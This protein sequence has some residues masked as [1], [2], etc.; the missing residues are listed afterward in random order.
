MNLLIVIVFS[1]L[2]L[3]NRSFAASDCEIFAKQ[4]E[5]KLSLI[6][7]ASFAKSIVD[8]IRENPYVFDHFK[9]TGKLSESLELNDHLIGVHWIDGTSEPRVYQLTLAGKTS[10]NIEIPRGWWAKI[11]AEKEF[12]GEAL[13]IST[14]QSL[15]APVV[16]EITVPNK[17]EKQQPSP[18][19]SVNANFPEDRLSYVGNKALW[20]N[21]G[22]KTLMLIVVEVARVLGV[23]TST[24]T[25]I[26]AFNFG[27]VSSKQDFGA[28]MRHFANSRGYHELNEV[29]LKF[30]YEFAPDNILVFNAP[31]SPF[32]TISRFLETS[33]RPN[34][35]EVYR[36]FRSVGELEA[37]AVGFEKSLRY[38]HD[39]LNDIITKIEK[40]Q[41]LSASQKLELQTLKQNNSP[42]A[43]D[44]KLNYIFSRFKLKNNDE[45]DLTHKAA[46]IQRLMENS[47]P[48]KIQFRRIA[49]YS[50]AL[51]PM[52]EY[53][54]RLFVKVMHDHL[55]KL[56]LANPEI[57]APRIRASVPV[58]FKLIPN[59]E[60][61]TKEITK[62]IVEAVT[63]E[64][65]VATAKKNS[66]NAKHSAER[67][68]EL[69]KVMS[70]VAN[71]T[72]NE[73]LNLALEGRAVTG[74]HF[75]KVMETAIALRGYNLE[76]GSMI[77]GLRLSV[78]GMGFR[79]E[80]TDFKHLIESTSQ[81][82]QLAGYRILKSFPEFKNPP[83][84][85]EGRIAKR[86]DELNALIDKVVGLMKLR[87]EDSSQGLN[88][89]EIDK[90]KGHRSYDD[91]PKKIGF[92]T[93]VVVPSKIEMLAQMKSREESNLLSQNLFY[94]T[95]DNTVPNDSK[96]KPRPMSEHEHKLFLR[97]VQELL[98]DLIRG[99]S[100]QP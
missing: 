55:D 28:L 12:P 40:T 23:E 41:N 100:I 31:K 36:V 53:E 99:G 81:P 35:N 71:T 80:I 68:A 92:L 75:G 42:H 94:D 91:F 8:A 9:Q 54:H 4:F 22:Q 48:L 69:L 19:I 88:L 70:D 95:C 33:E 34:L 49:T 62:E 87:N 72:E 52:S 50:K 96:L 47:D 65:D 16:K 10:V 39:S 6:K 29:A 7:D 18:V 93:S 67:K 25:N 74:I 97:T 83:L 30:G 63:D 21:N 5:F 86:H 64:E 27:I 57:I 89:T 45:Q 1:I 79:K 17:I 85:A 38:R 77:C 78:E 46:E 66:W 13:Q 61:T 14:K 32:M 58:Q 2:A 82:A 90:I 51:V 37:P 73:L 26:P 76:E 15:V 98:D 84:G 24:L 59:S 44:L 11:V 56:K 43:V 60:E 20:T 3:Q